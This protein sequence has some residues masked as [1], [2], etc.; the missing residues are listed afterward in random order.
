MK[1]TLSIMMLT[2]L[3]TSCALFQNNADQNHQAYCKEIKH[4]MIFNAA[5]PNQATAT[6]QRAEMEG[7]SRTYR[8]EDC[9]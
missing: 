4:R 9:S 5:T 1:Y 7:L 3:L 2:T 6:Q 8:N